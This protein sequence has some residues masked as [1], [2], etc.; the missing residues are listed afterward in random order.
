MVSAGETTWYI[1]RKPFSDEFLQLYNR[2]V[3]FYNEGHSNWLDKGIRAVVYSAGRWLVLEVEDYNM[4]PLD[5]WMSQYAVEYHAFW[6]DT[7]ANRTLMVSDP[8]ISSTPVGVDFY[9]IL[10]RGEQFGPL[11]ELEPL[12]IANYTGKGFWRCGP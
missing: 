7:Y 11:G 9:K 4:S 3:Y 2:P 12:K 8:T 6:D 10:D 1:P 5:E